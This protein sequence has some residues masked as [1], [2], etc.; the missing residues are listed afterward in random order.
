MTKRRKIIDISLAFAALLLSAGCSSDEA[1]PLVQPNGTQIR[2]SSA[3]VE[4]PAVTRTD[5]SDTYNDALT[6]GS[7]IGVYIYG[8][9]TSNASTG[10][11][12]SQY[13]TYPTAAN[14]ASK[15]WVYQT[16]GEA[17]AT[18]DGKQS[19]LVLTSHTKAPKFPVKVSNENDDMDHVDI[20]AVFPN[21]ADVT[22]STESYRFTVDLDQ[23]DEDK[24]KDADLMTNDI[25]KYTKDQCEGQSLQ[26]VLRHRMAKVHVTFIPKTGSDL[27]TAN[28]PTNFDVIGVRRTVVVTP[29]AGRVTLTT[30]GENSAAT[31]ADSPMLGT[32]S[33]SFFIPPQ[34]IN[35][36]STFLKFN[37]KA[38][39]DGRFKGIS[40]CTFAPSADFTFQAGYR[41]DITVTLD[42]DFVGVT[43]TITSWSE[44]TLPYSPVIL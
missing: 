39:A 20:F 1:A 7:S 18:S 24:I 16:V 43:G 42:V 4:T 14:D 23:R 22:P 44:E 28:M 31:T 17:V 27:T 21:N 11:D 38:N 15:T 12:I 36:N 3:S 9:E 41:Y 19:N 32:A 6:A 40:G 35:A 25:T 10:Y 34:T 5:A 37:I 8:Y 13:I 29:K 30:S 26:L 2:F 33:Q